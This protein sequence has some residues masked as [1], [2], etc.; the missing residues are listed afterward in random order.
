M[1]KVQLYADD[2]IFYQLLKY[3][4]YATTAKQSPEIGNMGAAEAHGVPF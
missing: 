2:R 4:E 1:S 3:L